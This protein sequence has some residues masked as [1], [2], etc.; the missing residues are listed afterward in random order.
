MSI[1]MNECGMMDG[2]AADMCAF[3]VDSC[4]FDGDG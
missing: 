4:D 2:E 1:D 3:V